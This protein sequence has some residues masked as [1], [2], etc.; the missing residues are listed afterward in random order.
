MKSI[1]VNWLIDWLIGGLTPFSTIFQSYLGGQF[2]HSYVSW[3]SHTSTSYNIPSKQLAAFPHRLIAHW[4]K[5]NDACHNDFCETS[6]RMLVELWFEFTTPGLTARVATDI[7]V[8]HTTMI[9]WACHMIWAKQHAA[10]SYRLF[11]GR[12][13]THIASNFVKRRK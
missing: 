1:K 9:I 7:K 8:K 10:F 12:W 4:W 5:T 6:E 11:G 3:L 2:T 13:M